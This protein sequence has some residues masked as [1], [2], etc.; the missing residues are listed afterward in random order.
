MSFKPNYEIEKCAAIRMINIMVDGLNGKYIFKYLT[1]GA[2]QLSF[3]E[4]LYQ[5]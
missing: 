1:S 4:N 5:L 3:S 2:M